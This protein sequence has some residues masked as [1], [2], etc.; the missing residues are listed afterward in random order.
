M[1]EDVMFCFDWSLEYLGEVGG[2]GLCKLNGIV[3]S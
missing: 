2:S 1:D 3:G